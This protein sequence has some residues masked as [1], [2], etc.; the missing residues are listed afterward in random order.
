MMALVGWLVMLMAM[1]LVGG[2]DGAD[3]YLSYSV[4]TTLQLIHEICW[5][6]AMEHGQ[7]NHTSG[8][9]RLRLCLPFSPRGLQAPS[10]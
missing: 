3:N 9:K 8:A 10:G 1:V 4:R 2:V 5:S 6:M 7:F